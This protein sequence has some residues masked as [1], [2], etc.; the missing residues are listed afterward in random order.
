MLEQL[1]EM[2]KQ[3]ATVRQSLERKQREIASVKSSLPLPHA[4]AT[5]EQ[6]MLRYDFMFYQKKLTAY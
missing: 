5:L 1:N 3:E 2:Q 4:I 6:E